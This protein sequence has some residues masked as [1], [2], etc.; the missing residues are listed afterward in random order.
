MNTFP[1]AGAINFPD[2]A[3]RPFDSRREEGQIAAWPEARGCMR[4]APAFDS[5]LGTPITDGKWDYASMFENTPNGS[6]ASTNLEP[7]SAILPSPT[8]NTGSRSPVG[9]MLGG[10]SVPTPTL[11]LPQVVL[12]KRPRGEDESP[13]DGGSEDDCGHGLRPRKKGRPQTAITNGVLE[14][15]GS[16]NWTHHIPAARTP[17]ETTS[18]SKAAGHG[19]ERLVTPTAQG[20]CHRSLQGPCVQQ[21]STGTL[22]Q[23]QPPWLEGSAQEATRHHP[24]I[25]MQQEDDE[26]DVAGSGLFDIPKRVE[27]RHFALL[28]ATPYDWQ[29]GG[30]QEALR[31]D[32]GAPLEIHFCEFCGD[33]F[34]RPDSLK[35]HRNNRPPQCRDTGP[36]I[37]E[38]KRRETIVAHER[39]KAWLTSCLETKK[40]IGM[41]FAQIIKEKYPNSSKKG[42]RQ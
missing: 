31:Q 1:S 28:D 18:K 36:D 35:R 41:P 14:A 30:V 37:A 20:V 16:T 38:T 5:E 25:M 10:S 40:E 34:A 32:G 17:P 13:D 29:L 23:E 33:F 7:T 27:N 19:A 22:A 3:S 15:G 12:G 11:V 9:W 42:S 26:L 8:L 39:F 21:E 4:P 2:V 24:N 6:D